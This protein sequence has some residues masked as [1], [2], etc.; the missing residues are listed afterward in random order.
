MPY[1]LD[2]LKF[3][4]LFA[5]SG[6]NFNSDTYNPVPGVMAGVPSSRNYD[7]GFTSKLMVWFTGHRM[8]WLSNISGLLGK[9]TLVWNLVITSTCVVHVSLSKGRA[10]QCK[11]SAYDHH[12]KQ[13]SHFI[14]CI[15]LQAKDLDLAMASASGVGFKCPMGSE[16]LEM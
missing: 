1:K 9:T 7:G 8:F 6:A 5:P 14:V 11:L 13:S 15:P 4:T 12:I 16:A 2:H 10:K 3:V